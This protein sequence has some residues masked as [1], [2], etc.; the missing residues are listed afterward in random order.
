MGRGAAAAT[1]LAVVAALLVPGVAAGELSDSSEG[2]VH[3]QSI[4]DLY[5]D[6]IFAGTECAPDQICPG[7]PIERWVMA[8]WLVRVLDQAEPDAVSSGRFADVDYGLWWGAHVERLAD[9]GITKGCARDPARYCPHEP[10]T[11]AQMAAFLVRA[12]NIDR[13]DEFGFVD[14]EGNTHADD[15]DALAAAAVTKGCAT[16]PARFCPDDYVSRAQMASLLNRARAISD[17]QQPDPEPPVRPPPAPS[18]RPPPPPAPPP[19]PPAPPPPAPPPPAPPPPAPP[20]PAPPAPAPPAPAPPAPP[21]PAPPP[22]A[23]APPAP[24]PPAPPPPADE[25]DASLSRIAYSSRGSG[26]AIFVMDADGTGRQRLTSN[27]YDDSDPVWSPDGTKIAYH[28]GDSDSKDEIFTMNADGGGSRK[29]TS[30]ADHARNPAWSPDGTK[31]AYYTHGTNDA[32]AVHVVDADGSAEP[33]LLR[34]GGHSPQWSPDGTRIAF[35][36]DGEIHVIDADGQNERQVT[37]DSHHS[38]EHF[39]WSPDSA[40][41]A[42]EHRSSIR[43]VDVADAADQDLG[44]GRKPVWSPD[45]TRIAYE[46]RSS[47]RVVDVADAA[48]QDLGVGREPVWSPDGTRIAYHAWLH[49]NDADIYVVDADGT[50]DR[51]QI[52]DNAVE[53]YKPVW[54]PD[55]TKIAFTSHPWDYE[56]MTMKADGTDKR[57]LTDNDYEDSHPAWSPDGARI[58]YVGT[59]DGGDSEIFVMDADGANVAQLTDNDLEDSDPAW[60]PDGARIVYVG[61]PDGGDSEIFVMDA[62]GANVAQLTDNDLEDSHPAWSPDGAKIAFD[63]AESGDENTR[64]IYVINADGETDPVQLTDNDRSDREP[65]WS[66]DGARIAYTFWPSRGQTEIFIMNADGADSERLTDDA[67][68]NYAPVWSPDG[69]LIAFNRNL[70]WFHLFKVI[71][72]DGAD[73]LTPQGTVHQRFGTDPAWSADSTRIAYSVGEIYAM[74]RDGRNNDRLTR[75]DYADIQP[76]WSPVPFP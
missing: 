68:H 17:A 51:E 65:A 52:T 41:I 2:G 54:S 30:S 44:E 74:D 28:T 3:Q 50:G 15:I 37:T 6:G 11:R 64:D 18:R 12:F 5:D 48:V 55:G 53:D 71:T 32:Y 34:T 40:S 38:D 26:V 75:N 20:A 27:S 13:A 23:P 43:V 29:V 46:H 72:P 61:T 57:Q 24:P 69:T 14:I 31:I 8:V 70:I 9:L 35:Y 47:I 33:T 16:E 10:V 25:H 1:V 19:P 59:P 21:P 7:R 67:Y 73:A 66:P 56:I 62:D 60:S 4:D 39:A 36:A 58:V 42:Y 22:P 76:A 45:G 49:S 63:V